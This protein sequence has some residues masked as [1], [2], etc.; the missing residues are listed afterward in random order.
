MLTWV[1][2]LDDLG[3]FD[4]A[5]ASCRKAIELKPDYVGGTC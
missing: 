4:E 1:S 5:E 3:R 2:H